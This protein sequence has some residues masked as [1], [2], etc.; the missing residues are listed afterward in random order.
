MGSEAPTTM[1]EASRKD[2]ALTIKGNIE[3][4]ISTPTIPPPD[5][6]LGL[7]G[8]EKVRD[9]EG[10]RGK[11]QAPSEG[12]LGFAIGDI[13]AAPSVE[14]DYGKFPNIRI[15]TSDSLYAVTTKESQGGPRLDSVIMGEG[16]KS[17]AAIEVGS[18]LGSMVIDPE[19][20]PRLKGDEANNGPSLML[21]DGLR[22]EGFA[23]DLGKPEP[24]SSLLT[25]LM[26]PPRAPPM[27]LASINEA[28][29]LERSRPGQRSNAPD[30]DSPYAGP[31][32]FS[33]L[34]LRDYG[35][36]WQT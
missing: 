12:N 35:E 34:P 7:K 30:F 16:S 36:P 27:E 22:D 6:G 11:N 1:G 10:I 9:L 20:E 25:V 33:S 2:L 19:Q 14:P 31:C 21:S 5:Y 13:L 18:W 15:L 23:P 26:P 28:P 29:G 4:K 8:K 3:T 17:Q 24:L 32:P